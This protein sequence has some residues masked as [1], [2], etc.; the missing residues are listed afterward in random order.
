MP[1]ILRK[2]AYLLLRLLLAGT[3]LVESLGSVDSGGLTTGGLL[4]EVIES[5]EASIE[6]VLATL[7]HDYD[8]FFS[9]LLDV[10]PLWTF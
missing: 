9:I 10:Q 2:L 3:W 8:S 4:A 1:T 6:I 7:A 5:P